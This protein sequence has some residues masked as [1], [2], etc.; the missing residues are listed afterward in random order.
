LIADLRSTSSDFMASKT[1]K[2]RLDYDEVARL[3]AVTAHD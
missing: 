2:T 3:L 1:I